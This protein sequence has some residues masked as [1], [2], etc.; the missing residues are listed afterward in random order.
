[1]RNW[2]SHRYLGFQRSTS[3]L[4]KCTSLCPLAMP[5]NPASRT[6]RSGRWILIRVS[7]GRIL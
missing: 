6:P 1:M 4:G 5:C 2:T 7:A 3:R